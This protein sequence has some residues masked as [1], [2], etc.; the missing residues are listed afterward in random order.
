MRNLME[1]ERLGRVPRTRC[2]MWPLRAQE[3]GGAGCSRVQVVFCVS[4]LQP[5]V[6]SCARATHPVHVCIIMTLVAHSRHAMRSGWS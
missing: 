4:V 2:I 3:T 5:A 6:T 1:K